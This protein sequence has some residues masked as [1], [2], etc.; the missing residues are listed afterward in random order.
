MAQTQYLIV[1]NPT[2]EGMG[3]SLLGCIR[4]LKVLQFT[5]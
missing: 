5:V 1:G 3:K 2:A 4:D